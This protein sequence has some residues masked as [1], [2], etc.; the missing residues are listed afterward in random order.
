MMETT[1]AVRVFRN[2][3][4]ELCLPVSEWQTEHHPSCNSV[5]EVAS[6]P[7][8]WVF[9]NRG[10]ASYVMRVENSETTSTDFVLKGQLYKRDFGSSQLKKRMIEARVQEHFTASKFVTSIYGQCGYS[11][12]APFSPGGSLFDYIVSMK[13][14]G[15]PKLSAVDKLKIAIHL[16]SGVAAIHELDNTRP[17]ATHTSA[18][19]HNDLDTNQF[20]FHEGIF[21]LTDFNYGKQMLKRLSDGSID[22]CFQL[23]GMHPYVFRSPEDLGYTYADYI[24]QDD[25]ESLSGNKTLNKELKAVAKGK[26]KPFDYSQSDVYNMGHALHSLW[27]LQWM[28][29]HSDKYAS[30]V[31]A[32]K[33]ERPPLNVE[34]VMAKSNAAG[35][36][37][38][39]STDKSRKAHN[40]IAKAIEMCWT[41]DP[42]ERPTAQQVRVYLRQQLA[43]ILGFENGK[44]V[45]LQHLR[46]DLPKPVKRNDKHGEHA[47]EDFNNFLR[48]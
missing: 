18:Y 31:K 41:H 16:A 12:L 21:T 8:E 27:T 13:Y 4:G 2:A 32:L 35:T 22:A 33:G 23:P 24:R 7:N 43:E 42:K 19:A 20:I 3:D 37:A 28:W 6:A 9:V 25:E 5:H 46:L 39:I 48:L 1:T 38:A 30:L 29:N 44:D 11:F 36:T 14:H 47:D 15:E 40:V 34:A 17:N 45:S 10:G 26:D